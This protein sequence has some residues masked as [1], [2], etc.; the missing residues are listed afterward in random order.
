MTAMTITT[1]TVPVQSGP[2][3]RAGQASPRGGTRL[4][5]RGR[6]VLLAVAVLLLL[7]AFS[8]GRAASQAATTVE[9]GPALTQTTVHQGDTLWSV[10]HRLAPGNDPRDVIA[11]I[12]QVN[13]LSGSDLVAG[14]QLLLPARSS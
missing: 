9:H 10:A 7:A 13:H 6:F 3:A 4:T 14:Q 5:P 1:R 8:L 12:Q 2:A 11:R